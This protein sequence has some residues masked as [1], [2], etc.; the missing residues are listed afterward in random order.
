M[1]PFKNAIKDICALIAY[2][3]PLLIIGIDELNIVFKV[4]IA[5]ITFL[6]NALY[7]YRTSN[8]KRDFE[9]LKHKHQ[10]D[11][12][13]YEEWLK[14]DEEYIAFYKEK[15]DEVDIDEE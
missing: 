11:V 14:K 8:L 13:R 10:Q 15:L 1:K 4:I 6:Y 3:G 9:E 5:A 2:I 7:H 12:Q